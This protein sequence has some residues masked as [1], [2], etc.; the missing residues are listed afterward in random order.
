MTTTMTEAELQ[1][2]VIE[3]ARLLGWLVA[4]FRSVPVKRGNRVVH[5]TPVQA[6]GAGWPDLVLVRDRLLA[7]EL[8][9]DRRYPSPE[10][11]LWLDALGLAGVETH[12]WRPAQWLDGTIEAVLRQRRQVAA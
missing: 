3:L 1:A 7:V 12:V 5:M 6:D 10:Q 9:Q 8:K 11:R 2:N 4:H